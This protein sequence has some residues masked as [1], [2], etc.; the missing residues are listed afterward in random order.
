MPHTISVDDYVNTFVSGL[1]PCDF[2]CSRLFLNGLWGDIEAIQ[3][4]K[5]ALELGRRNF[6]ELFVDLIHFP[7]NKIPIF[8]AL[9]YFDY[10]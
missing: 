4:A 10:H 6:L 9:Y 8:K 3:P 5:L 1:A 7:S 2:L